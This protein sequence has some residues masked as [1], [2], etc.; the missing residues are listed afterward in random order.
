VGVVVIIRFVIIIFIIVVVVIIM[1]IIIIV[2]IIFNINKKNDL[3]VN[4]FLCDVT[5]SG[6]CQIP[7]VL[8]SQPSTIFCYP[9]T[10]PS[11]DGLIDPLID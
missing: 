6:G 5:D 8:I 2:N 10:W 3:S 1:I 11:G 7:A 4:I 9:T